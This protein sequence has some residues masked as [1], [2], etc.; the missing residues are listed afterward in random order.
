MFDNRHLTCGIQAT[1]P[2]EIVSFIWCLIDDMLQSG[3]D[4]DYLQVFNLWE[5]ATEMGK[6]IQMISHIQE[7][8]DYRAIYILS[9]SINPISAKIFVI[10][11]V[12]H[13]TMLLA[14]EY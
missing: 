1:I 13:S 3:H 5:E 8:P 10:D 11:D 2:T 4:V 14:Q 12:S 6:S 7:N 9:Q